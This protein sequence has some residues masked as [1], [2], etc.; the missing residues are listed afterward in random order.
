MYGE[1]V[2]PETIAELGISYTDMPSNSFGISFAAKD[3]ECS[4]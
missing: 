1:W 4:G 3:T 2:D